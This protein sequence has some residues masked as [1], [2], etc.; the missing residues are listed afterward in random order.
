[1]RMAIAIDAETGFAYAPEVASAECLTG[2]CVD[3]R[4]AKRHRSD[5]SRSARS[6]GQQPRYKMLLTPL[7]DALGFPVK[8]SASLPALESPKTR[9]S[10]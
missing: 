8:F 4:A 1:M 5:E 10:R 6:P 7:A 2:D 3:K 9:S